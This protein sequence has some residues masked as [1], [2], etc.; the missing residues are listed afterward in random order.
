MSTRTVVI[1]LAV[2]AAA[3][4]LF[5]A[6]PPTKVEAANAS[7]VASRAPVVV[8]IDENVLSLGGATAGIGTTTITLGK[9][10]LGR[11]L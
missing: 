8:P 1:F 7:G 5:Y 4:V 10:S 3:V 6:L 2:V 11:F 9:F